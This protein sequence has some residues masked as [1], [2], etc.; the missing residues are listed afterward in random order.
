MSRLAL[1]AEPRIRCLFLFPR[2]YYVLVFF[3]EGL[4]YLIHYGSVNAV[5]LVIMFWFLFV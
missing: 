2:F 1:Q 4:H 3:D 5:S